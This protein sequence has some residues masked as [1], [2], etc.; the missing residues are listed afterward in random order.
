MT[1]AVRIS[2]CGTG[3]ANDAVVAPAASLD[4]EG[5][6]RPGEPGRGEDQHVRAV[7]QQAEPDDQLRQAAPQHHVDARRVQQPAT[8]REQQLHVSPRATSPSVKTIVSTTPITARKTPTSKSSGVPTWPSRRFP[9]DRDP[10]AR[11]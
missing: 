4:D 10:H 1:M 9:A 3:S 11:S 6:P 5:R 2:A 7:R 8:T